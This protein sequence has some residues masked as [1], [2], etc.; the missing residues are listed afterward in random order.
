MKLFEKFKTATQSDLDK[1]RAAL[2]ESVLCKAMNDLKESELDT[3]DGNGKTIRIWLNPRNQKCFNWGWFV[4]QDFF[5]WTQGKGK[6]VKG[7]TDEEKKKFWD[8]AMFESQHDYAW[9][10]GY[11]KKYFGCIDETYHPKSK[12]NYY[13]I[14]RYVEKPLKIT[15]TN[16]E[17]IIA[18]VFGDICAYYSDTELTYESGHHRRI[19]DEVDGAKQVLYTLGVGYYGACNTPEEP[20]NLSW[21]SDICIYKSV[22]LY[23]L[24]N[25]VPL[26]DF[27]FVY[28]Y[29]DQVK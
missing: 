4:Y 14:E 5:D 2:K 16:H 29:K 12:P 24:K 27:D 19:R 17:E 21:I 22:Y 28:N 18:K 13:S 9:A 8:V 20:L 25:N 26:P 3:A 11:N 23:F 10:I 6:I 1:V 15:K 7:K